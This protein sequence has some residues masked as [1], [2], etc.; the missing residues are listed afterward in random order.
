MYHFQSLYSQIILKVFNNLYFTFN[1]NIILSQLKQKNS[2]RSF[3]SRK[4]HS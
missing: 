1:A 4:L 2:I 3:V